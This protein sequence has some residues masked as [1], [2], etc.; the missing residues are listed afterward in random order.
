[1]QI[2]NNA[3]ALFA[4]LSTSMVFLPSVSGALR[5]AACNER[6]LTLRIINQT[7]IQP[8]SPFFVMV[9]NNEADPLYSR[10]QPASTALATLAE[11][12]DTSELIAMYEGQDGVEEVFEAGGL[13][14]P[15]YTTEIEVTV[16]DDYPLVTIASMCVNTND[17]FVSLNGAALDRGM[18]INTPG[19]DAG[20]EVNNEDCA[21]IPGPA[22]ANFTKAEGNCGAGE[23]YV[24]VHRGI[25]GFEGSDLIPADVDW[26]NPMM[27]VVVE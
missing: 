19:N 1:M 24:H 21:C 10:G 11:E 23:G 13:T 8:F 18:T 17:C 5:K 9:H 26:R 20:S 2:I 3:I 25:H 7:F 12:G 16:S 15:G 27:R 14:L 6:T 4:I 22:C